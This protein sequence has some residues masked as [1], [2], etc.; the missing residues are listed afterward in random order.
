MRK[1]MKYKHILSV[2]AIVAVAS[3]CL[4]EVNPA[5]D[6]VIFKASCPETKTQLMSNG[7]IY[8]K[9]GDDINIFY[10]GKSYKF[11][12]TNTSV[13]DNVEFQGSMDGIARD[14]SKYVV[15]IY[16]YSDANT[17]TKDGSGFCVT[18]PS[19]QSSLSGTFADDLF[20][21][22]ARTKDN[23]LRFYNICGGI[24]FS[25]AVD[26]V[27]KIVFRGNNNETVAGRFNVVF[28]GNEEIPDVSSIEQSQTSVTLTA[29][30]GGTFR[31]GDFYYMALI[32]QTFKS[33]YTI[34]FYS[35]KLMGKKEYDKSVTVHRA[36]W[37]VINNMKPDENEPDPIVSVS[38]SSEQLSFYS[39]A[40]ES[41]SKTL[42]IKNTGTNPITVNSITCD[43][44]FSCYTGAVTI[45]ANKSSDFI[46]DFSPASASAFEGKARITV[47]GTKTF[48]I[49]LQGRAY[50]YGSNQGVGFFD[51]TLS[52][53]SDC[54]YKTDA[55][56]L[57]VFCDYGSVPIRESEYFY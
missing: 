31:Q 4:K 17:C 23:Y 21:S 16:P 32:P 43:S 44:P 52:L 37:G 39:I 30:G 10:E 3:S 51:M 13:S 46:I 49:G 34:E 11:T 24:K 56:Y 6:V 14:L 48:E 41:Y 33:G 5:Q 2:L 7:A 47:N 1:T 50:N 26:G 28:P 15:G 42:T 19:D 20:P 12:S 40:G 36:V 53:D 8:W 38:F 25:V 18:L 54:T 29:P 9:P 27:K 55:G 45:A 22:V 57:E 35:D